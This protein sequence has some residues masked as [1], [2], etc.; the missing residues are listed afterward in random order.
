MNSIDVS[1]QSVQNGKD[2]IGIITHDSNLIFSIP[3]FYISNINKKAKDL[4]YDEVKKLKILVRAWKKYSSKSSIKSDLESSN[5]SRDYNFNTAFEIIQDFVEYG[6]Y[7]EYEKKYVLTNSGKIDFVKTIKKC[8]PL[9]TDQGPIY[10]EYLRKS[11]SLSDELLLQH[12]QMFALTDISSKIGW[13]LGFNIKFAFHNHLINKATSNILKRLKNTTFNSRKLHLINLLVSYLNSQFSQK[14]N[15]ENG[16]LVS[17]AHVFW[18]SILF[19]TLQSIP[20]NRISKF[21]NIHHS[22]F[23]NDDL[24]I[25]FTPLRPDIIVEK[26]TKTQVID[27]KYYVSNNLPQ[28]EDISKQILYLEKAKLVNPQISNF[29]NYFILPTDSPTYLSDIKARFDTT[30]NQSDKIIHL[31]YMNVTSVINAYVEGLKIDI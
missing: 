27:A 25:Q 26:T 15:A 29:E 16:L 10:L 28:S 8:K 30:S 2:N 31:Y 4:S 17:P 3:A 12:V 21:Y 6:L 14:I 7:N 1:I 24:Y 11:K 23:Q 9:Y 13:L 18:E 20:K 22:Y 5:E 19:D